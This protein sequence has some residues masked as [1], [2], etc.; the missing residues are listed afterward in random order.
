MHILQVNNNFMNSVT[1][2]LY[3]K[4][5]DYCVL[6][7]CGEWDTLKP[8]LERIGKKVKTV[9]LTH[10]HADHIYGINGLL[11]SAPTVTIGTNECGHNEL[12]DPKKNLSFFHGNPVNVERYHPLVLKDGMVLPFQGLTDIEVIA[13]PGHSSSC[14]SYKM[15]RN[16]FTGDAYIPGINTCTKLPGGNKDL[17]LKSITLLSDMEQSGYK[18]YCGHHH[19]D[20][21][22]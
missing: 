1:Y 16:L 6:I 20:G 14:L 19:Y 3:S 9:L 17:A 8:V 5:V 4:N 15:G 11:E 22:I 13:T 18:I 12:C 10:G 7:D 2:V 21:L